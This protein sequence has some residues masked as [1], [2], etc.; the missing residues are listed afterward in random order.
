M[1]IS[2]NQNI[3][4][5]V[6]VLSVIGCLFLTSI[7]QKIKFRACI[8]LYDTSADKYTRA[9]K[10]IVRKYNVAGFKV[11]QVNTDNEF[12]PLLRKFEEDSDI[13]FNFCIADEDVPEAERNNRSIED[14]VRV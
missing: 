2:R 11:K 8:P 4:L 3:T 10:L 14:R 13:S 5:C 7:D 1:I 6:D 9:M 12:Q